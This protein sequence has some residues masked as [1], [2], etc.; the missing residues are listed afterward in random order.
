MSY[1]AVKSGTLTEKQALEI[2]DQDNIDR[3]KDRNCD[4]TNRL[5]DDVYDVV[6]FSASIECEDKKGNEAILVILYLVGKDDLE[7]NCEDLGGC[8]WNNYTFEIIYN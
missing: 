5:I 4:Y 7:K 6:E 8:N 1:P 2:V 3:V